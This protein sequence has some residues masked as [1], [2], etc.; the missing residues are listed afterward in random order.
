MQ[1]NLEH[2]FLKKDNLQN[3]FFRYKVHTEQG[4]GNEIGS[5]GTDRLCVNLG[6]SR[7]MV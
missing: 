6:K 2:N 7:F 3:Q 5:Y 1:L 4:G